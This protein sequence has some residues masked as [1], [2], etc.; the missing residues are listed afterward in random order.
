MD[1]LGK[2]GSLAKLLLE[3]RDVSPEDVVRVVRGIRQ[4]RHGDPEQLVEARR[5]EMNGEVVDTPKHGQASASVRL[6][7]HHGGTRRGVAS[8]RPRRDD[9]VTICEEKRQELLWPC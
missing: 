2:A 3:R 9:A 4:A 1:P 6:R 7:T 5:L 8:T